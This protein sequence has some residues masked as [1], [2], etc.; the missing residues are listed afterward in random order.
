V[1]TTVDLG[2][3]ICDR[4][5][6]FGNPCYCPC[7]RQVTVCKKETVCRTECCPV[8][9]CKKVAVCVP[10]TKQVTTCET[11]CETVQ[12]PV[13]RTR[14]VCETVQ[15]PVTRTRCV[16]TCE[17]RT[18]TTNVCR[19]VPYQ[20]TRCVTV[21]EPVCENVT[22]CKLVPTQVQ[23]QVQ[24][25]TGGN[26]GCGSPCNTGCG[27]PCASVCDPCAHRAGLFDHLRGHLS[28][29][30][31]RGCDPCGKAGLFG[32]WTPGSRLGGLCKKNTCDT[33]CS[34]GGCGI[35]AG[36]GGCGGCGH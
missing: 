1:P 36:F 12:V 8:T 2:P 13:C 32:G 20:A 27:N 26:A 23:K 22:V 14:M 7:P 31:N 28:G 35:S 19:T 3:S 34:T 30:F 33:G 15:C 21:C 16:P 4:F 25:W 17:A 6:A 24:V 29:M 9:V 11:V 18:C 5:K 10:V